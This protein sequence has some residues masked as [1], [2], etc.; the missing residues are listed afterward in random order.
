MHELETSVKPNIIPYWKPM[1]TTLDDHLPH[2]D[3]V[4]EQFCYDCQVWL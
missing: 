1:L 2:F 4:H 3:R